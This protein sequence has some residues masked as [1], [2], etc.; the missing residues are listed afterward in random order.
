MGREE[1]LILV[2]RATPFEG[3]DEIRFPER[4]DGVDEAAVLCL[5]P[6]VG[7]VILLPFVSN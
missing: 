2:R 4:V 5:S 6:R 7:M 3:L 1:D